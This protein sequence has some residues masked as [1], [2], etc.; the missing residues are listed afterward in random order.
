MKINKGIWFV[1]ALSIVGT[2]VIYPSLPEQIPVH[3]NVKGEIDRY[4]DKWFAIV[5]ASFPIL[6]AAL[7]I[8]LPKI[9]PRRDSYQKH[10]KAYVIFM[11]VLLVFFVL[12]HW[13]TVGVSLGYEINV[14][15]F[16]GSAVGVL[17]IVIGN[18]MGQIR[19]NYF[20]G[21]R[22]PWTLANEQVWF[23]T[24]RRGG[25]IF[26]IAGILF[27]INGFTGNETLIIGSLIFLFTSIA[28]I[29]VYSYLEFR[30]IEK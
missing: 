5:T 3:W 10:Q 4:S 6:F 13:V 22:T 9:D 24:H 14:G 15:L 28:Y 11:N 19:H 2:F 16:I 30:K 12:L 8:F 20:F 21:I 26:I 7:M 23:K 17:F 29:T 25:W 27:I 1:I 18:Y